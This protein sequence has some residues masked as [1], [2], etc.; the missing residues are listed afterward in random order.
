MSSKSAYVPPHLRNQSPN[1]SL[2][3]SNR[4]AVLETAD[5]RSNAK[6]VQ[7]AKTVQIEPDVPNI[8]LMPTTKPL[9]GAWANV[10]QSVYKPV[11]KTSS[12]CVEK[13]A[14]DN[15]IVITPI[16]KVERP[17]PLSLMPDD[18]IDFKPPTYDSENSDSDSDSGSWSN[19]EKASAGTGSS[20]SDLD[21]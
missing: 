5:P 21:D 17:I 8:K 4:F 9:T 2:K 15:K 20:N 14:I 6:T 13:D 1:K 7:S 3:T 18:E 10:N 16:P 12:Q 19:D 11:L